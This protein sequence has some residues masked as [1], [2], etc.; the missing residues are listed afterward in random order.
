MSDK[1][2]NLPDFNEISGMASKLFKDISTSVN[3]IM[4]TYKKSR[5]TDKPQQ[6]APATEKPA[7]SAEKKPEPAPEKPQD[8]PVN[9]NKTS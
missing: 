2:S 5:E 7:A 6:S 8:K 4:D 9:D 3:Q 1:K